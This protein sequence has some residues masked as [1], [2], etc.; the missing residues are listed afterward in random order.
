[1]RVNLNDCVIFNADGQDVPIVAE[2]I[3]HRSED[4]DVHFVNLA[5]QLV[6]SIIQHDVA[7]GCVAWLTN[8]PVLRALS[9]C[10]AVSILVQKEDFL[11]PDS[12]NGW[13]A[14]ELRELYRSLP[15]FDRISAEALYNYASDPTTDAVRCVGVAA[16]RSVTPPRMHHKFLVLCNDR[17]GTYEPSAVWTGSFN[18]THNATQSLENA[19]VIRRPEI[20]RVYMQEWRTLLGL[21]EPLNWSSQYVEPDFRIGT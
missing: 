5:E 1:M 8:R 17:D 4:I 18:F 6:A 13:S 15:C 7:I 2:R 3:G 19:L 20:A 10:K 12:G 16:D 21:S 9:Q 11:R 14:H